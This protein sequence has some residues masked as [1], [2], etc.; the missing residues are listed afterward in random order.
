[1]ETVVT[2]LL[3]SVLRTG[4]YLPMG[5]MDEYKNYSEQCRA[6]ARSTNNKELRQA[7]TKMA[8]VWESLAKEH[9]ARTERRKRM[10]ASP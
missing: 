2:D 3:V 10:V 1:M 6:M 9:V 5:E 8:E 4:A 7:L